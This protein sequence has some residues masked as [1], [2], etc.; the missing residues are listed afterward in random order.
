MSSHIILKKILFYSCAAVLASSQIFAQ[1]KMDLTLDKAVEIGLQSSKTIAIS[2]SKV[3][4]AKAR[5]DEADAAMY[6]TLRLNGSYSRLS[7]VKPFSFKIPVGNNQYIENTL[8][9]SIVNNYSAKLSLNQPLFVG[10]RLSANSEL[11][12]YNAM[13]SEEDL[14]KDKI[15]LVH[16][17]KTAYWALFKIIETIKSLDENIN[18][19]K[20]HL[21]DL[22]NM[23]E[24]G[25][26]TNNDVLKVKV[27]LSNL[28]YS[29]LDVESG[30]DAAMMS[31]NN[32]LGIKIDS[33][34]NPISKPNEISE[35]ALDEQNL[36]ETAKQSRADL[37]SMDLRVKA[38]EAAVT[39]SKAGWYPQ[40]SFSANYTYAN[41][42]QRYFPQREEFK[43]SWDMGL[44]LSYDIWNWNTSRYQ[45]SQANANLDQTVIAYNQI[46]DFVRLEVSQSVIGVRKA[47]AKIP[48]AEEGVRQAEENY[49]VTYEKFK[50]GLATNSDLLDSESA[51]LISKINKISALADIEIAKA[52]LEKS[53][54]K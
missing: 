13:A 6:P 22:E 52:K 20:A 45:S 29:K 8:S 16:D 23:M 50:S 40:I 48:V 5:A 25:L 46:L 42:N 49:R 1:E 14:K 53:I 41:P 43:G 27:Q 39:I 11:A 9:P 17:I 47:M 31:L 30:L 4:A 38:S 37:K 24:V 51:L 36:L 3:E 34:I 19:T 28:E 15:Q 10:N 32:A 12:A 18:Q 26:A 2:N 33:K 54:G 21:K 44:S 35:I 7:E